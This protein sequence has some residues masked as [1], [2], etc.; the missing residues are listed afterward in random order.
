MVASNAVPAA[1][2]TAPPRMNGRIVRQLMAWRTRQMPEPC[3]TRPHNTMRRAFGAGAMMCSHT[4][5]TTRPIANPDR[6]DVRPPK[7]AA[8]R[9]KAKVTLLIIRLVGSRPARRRSGTVEF[10]DA[11][12]RRRQHVQPV[13]HDQC[14]GL[15]AA[16][17][18]NPA[19]GA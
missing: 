19:H 14:G 12:V 16:R 1:T 3:V 4:P 18:D 6:P 9:K 15:G 2:P 11:A 17:G 7:N 8:A 5:E 10:K 13:G